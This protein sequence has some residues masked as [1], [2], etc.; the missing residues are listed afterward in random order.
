M[1][2]FYIR[3]KKVPNYYKNN[4][5]YPWKERLQ[6]H[7]CLMDVFHI[8]FGNSWD[9][10]FQETPSGSLW[11]KRYRFIYY[12]EDYSTILFWLG[13]VLPCLFSLEIAS[14]RENPLKICKTVRNE[15]PTVRP[16]ERQWN[17]VTHGEILRVKRS[18]K[19]IRDELLMVKRRSWC[20]YILYGQN[21]WENFEMEISAC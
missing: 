10:Y 4:K 21:I 15:E 13:I 5:N 16:W 3:S 8:I 17:R 20:F 7:W 14:L 11:I 2:I 19:L 12:V 6:L 9:S 18:V 1:G